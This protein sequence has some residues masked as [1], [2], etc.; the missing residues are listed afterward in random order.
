MTLNLSRFTFDPQHGTTLRLLGDPYE[1]HRFVY[2][3]MCAR[4]E[5]GRLL[6]RLDSGIDLRDPRPR[7]LVQTEYAVEADV[8][9]YSSRADFVRIE[10]KSVDVSFK[11]EKPYRFRARVNPV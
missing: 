7:L 10:S 2:A 9:R 1:L 8:L 4:G 11:P 3:V 6:Y 5:P